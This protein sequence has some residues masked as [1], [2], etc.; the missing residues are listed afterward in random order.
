MDSSGCP[1]PFTESELSRLLPTKTLE[2]YHRLRQS[3]E[4]AAA[5]IDGL[6]SC[7]ACSYAV[8]IENEAEKLFICQNEGCKQVSCRKCKN[9]VCSITIC[10]LPA[11]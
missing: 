6:E 4:L 3:A 9:K 1:A 7:P 2:L 10:C 11:F 5:A 8:I